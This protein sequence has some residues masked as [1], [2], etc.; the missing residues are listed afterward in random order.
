M[1]YEGLHYIIYVNTCSTT[2]PAPLPNISKCHVPISTAR[3]PPATHTTWIPNLMLK[4]DDKDRLS[5]PTERLTD[6]IINAAQTLLKQHTT[7]YVGFQN[8]PLGAILKFKPLEKGR[9]FI[10]ILH[11][12]GNHWITSTN[13]G[14]KAGEIKLFDSAV[15]S[16]ITL[17]AKQQ[18][19]SFLLPM[20]NTV[21][22]NL[23]NM[24]VQPDS[25][26]CGLFS[27]TVA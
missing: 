15:N 1:N 10:Q 9:P 5:S 19:C 11:V 8:T 4:S 7:T 22:F 6:T 18:I 26:S 16:Y 17:H 27:I 13:A 2:I 23:V 21:K 12:N 20:E 3:A 14:C 25:A 24:Q